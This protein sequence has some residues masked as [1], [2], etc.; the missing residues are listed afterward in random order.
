MIIYHLKYERIWHHQRNLNFEKNKKQKQITFS[1][2]HYVSLSHQR[3]TPDEQT[4]RHHRHHWQ[5]NQ[6]HENHSFQQHRGSGN[7]WENSTHYRCNDELSQSQDPRIFSFQTWK[8]F[9]QAW[10]PW[11]QK[12]WVSLQAYWSFHQR[13]NQSMI[14]KS[15]YQCQD[16]Q[17]SGDA[18]TMVSFWEDRS[19]P[20]QANHR[21]TQK[22]SHKSFKCHFKRTVE[23]IWGKC[24]QNLLCRICSFS[25]RTFY[26]YHSFS[27]PP[28]WSSQC[29]DESWVYF[30][31][32][33]HSDDS[34]G[35][36]YWGTAWFFSSAKRPQKSLGA[37]FDGDV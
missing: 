36:R 14:C 1:I 7:F 12:Y 9:W 24:L 37:G 17:L 25:Q 29:Y 28:S 35:A 27:S 31:R 33:D 21:W 15:Y 22:F 13:W 10:Q 32:S 5:R 34:F 23:R 6:S 30:S 4:R 11:D 3:C 2:Y 26:L 16:P 19:N 20:T 8:L 18:P